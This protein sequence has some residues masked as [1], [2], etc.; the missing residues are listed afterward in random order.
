MNGRSR[1]PFND[2]YGF[3]YSHTRING[4]NAIAVIDGDI[5]KLAVFQHDRRIRA[6]QESLSEIRYLAYEMQNNYYVRAR[7]RHDRCPDRVRFL[8][9]ATARSTA[10]PRD[11]E[12]HV[13]CVISVQTD[14]DFLKRYGRT[15]DLISPLFRAYL[16]K[17]KVTL[18]IVPGRQTS[19]ARYFH[20]MDND[21]YRAMLNRMEALTPKLAAALRS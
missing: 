9:A 13:R 21:R 20:D 3:C 17:R 1:Q 4:T 14:S 19:L 5:S 2:A 18:L 6:I 12:G 7:L 10:L 16:R 8:I 15:G 11:A